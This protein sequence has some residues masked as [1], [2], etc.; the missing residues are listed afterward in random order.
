M[1]ASAVAKRNQKRWVACFV[2]QTRFVFVVQLTTSVEA[3]ATEFWGRPQ[4]EPCAPHFP[5]HTKW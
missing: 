1:S 5:V 2:G 4:N 3:K